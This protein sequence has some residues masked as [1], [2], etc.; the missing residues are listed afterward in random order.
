MF[1]CFGFGW[2]FVHFNFGAFLK[3][4][5]FLDVFLI[6]I[7][8]TM[9]SLGWAYLVFKVFIEGEGSLRDVW[10]GI[11]KY[12]FKAMGVSIISGFVVGISLFNIRFYFHL[13]NPHRFTDFLLMGFIAWIL[14]FWISS[15]AYYWPV[16]FF[17]NPPFL[18]IFYKSFLLVL[19][20]WPL[21]ILT[22]FICLAFILL[23]S[24]VWPLWFFVGGVLL[25]SLQCVTLEKQLSNV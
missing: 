13:N 9:I 21:S 8:E 20:N 25:F 23:F 11:R 10:L 17:Q 7:L 5:R 24:I 3:Q 1:S 19:G 6:Y 2:L 16:L 4:I 12:I 18:K 22:L 15:S 14:A